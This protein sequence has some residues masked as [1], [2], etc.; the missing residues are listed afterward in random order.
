MMRATCF[1]LGM[2]ALQACA[3][4]DPAVPPRDEPSEKAP[5]PARSATDLTET[6]EHVV[7]DG[8]APGVSIAL[9]HPS[10]APWWAAAG[11]ASLDSQAALTTNHRFRAGSI[12]K[13]GV[14][15][16]VLQLVERGALDLDADL[17]ELLPADVS[18]RIPDADAI[19]LRMLLGHTSGLADYVDAEYDGMFAENPL[20]IWTFD[21]VLARALAMPRTFPP[22]AGWSYT[23]TGYLLLGKILETATGE[24]WRATLRKNVLAR[25]KM[26]Q[27]ELPE[28]GNPA[29]EGCSR[30]YHPLEAGLVDMTEGDPS[31]AGAA[32]G[33]ALI[34]TPRDLAR[35]LRAVASG[36]LFDDPA[37]LE[38]MTEFTDAPIPEETQTGYGL[39]LAHFDAGGTE[40]IGHLGG[41]AG[42]QSFVFLHPASGMVVSGSM[43]RFG[44]FGAFVLPVLQ[45]A[46][47]IE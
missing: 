3:S 44:D 25:A 12:L 11:V 9:D 37:T 39:G 41:T 43:N 21:E 30:G 16:A 46:A 7:A 5:L 31:M 36:S 4:A 20:R 38:L 29:C 10:Y 15:T 24:P 22:G 45:A 8:I 32:G 2:I 40:L 1:V 19:T 13:V 28:E 14:A 47:R 35:L 18:A 42:Y 6:L 26:T 33:E 34:T 27:S 17:N 23:N